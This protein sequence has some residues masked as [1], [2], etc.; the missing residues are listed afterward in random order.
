APVGP[1]PGRRCG[2]FTLVEIMIALT[3]GLVLLMGVAQMFSGSRVS[4]RI[5]DNLS[6]MQENGRFAADV[7]ETALRMADHWGGVETRVVTASGSVSGDCSSGWAMQAVGVMGY[8]GNNTTPLSGCIPAADY[9]ANS[10]LVVVRYADP[11]AAYDYSANATYDVGENVTYNGV[12][13]RNVTAVSTP[14][15]WAAAS[16]ETVN[17]TFFLRA[18]PGRRAEVLQSSGGGA[19]SYPSDLGTNITAFNYPF[20]VEA[21]FV[22]PCSDQ[23]AN[24]VCDSTDDGGSPIPT[25]TR[26]YLNQ[27]TLAQEPLIEGVEQLQLTYGVD[28][29]ADGTANRY[30]VASGVTDWSEVVSVRAGLVV[31]ALEK[32][33]NYADT[34]NLTL[35]G[36]FTYAPA[37]SVQAYYRKVFGKVIQVRN[38]I[39]S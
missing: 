28:S 36:N 18:G 5:Q 22:R 30:F 1:L 24:N 23:G 21:Y 34:R 8:E 19:L 20:R 31:R 29:D 3:L 17:S 14:A 38:R 37:T 27:G 10:D 26:L 11:D 32:D 39:R 9:V 4:Y 15:A 33:A 25:L 12:I 2:G 35:P 6:Y 16:W 7:L 13:Y